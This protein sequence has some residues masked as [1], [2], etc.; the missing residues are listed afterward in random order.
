MIE[1][2]KTKGT[3]GTDHQPEY[4]H[5]GPRKT[6]WLPWLLL[7]LGVLALLWYLLRHRTSD[8]VTTTTTATTQD[9]ATM[10]PA[11]APV[12]GKTETANVGQLAPYLAG[13]DAAPRTFNFDS[14]K[15]DTAKSDIRADD[16]AT[17]VDVA[18]ILTQYGATKVKIVGYADARGNAAANRELGQARADSVKAALVKAG[19]DGGRIETGSGGQNDP[20]DTNATASGQQENRRT[21]LVVT[22]R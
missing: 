14:L 16:Q 20:V 4:V 3:I 22:A 13:Q 2:T 9:A 1:P 5:L 7:A 19:I 17:I 8:A 10:A 15:F 11:A 18:K 21:E 12:V 6:N